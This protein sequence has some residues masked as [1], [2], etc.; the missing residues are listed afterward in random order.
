[1]EVKFLSQN[2]LDEHIGNLIERF[3][4]WRD[5]ADPILIGQKVFES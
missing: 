1:M 4:D 2:I 5:K 3:Y